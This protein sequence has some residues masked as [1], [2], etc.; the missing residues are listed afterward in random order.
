[1]VISLTKRTRH[2]YALLVICALSLSAC[3]FDTRTDVTQNKI[4]LIEHQQDMAVPMSALDAALLGKVADHYRRNGEGPIQF[5]V[6]YQGRQPD[7]SARMAADK[8]AEITAAFK[9]HGINE[10]SGT[11]MRVDGTPSETLFRYAYWQAKGP[12]DCPDVFDIYDESAAAFDEYDL[13][14]QNLTFIARQMARPSDLLGKESAS[15]SDGAVLTNQTAIHREGERLGEL[16][17][18]SVDQ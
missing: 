10:A 6:T 1:M 8:V 16:Q 12:A 5:T 15:D 13:G 18:M 14:C 4:R 2:L 17:G 9:K 7:F 3:S 11:L